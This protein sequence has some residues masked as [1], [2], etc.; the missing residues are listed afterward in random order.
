MLEKDR[1]RYAPLD[2]LS[3][4][5]LL[6]PFHQVQLLA[7]REVLFAVLF[8]FFEAILHCYFNDHRLARASTY[9][10]RITLGWLRSWTQ[11]GSLWELFSLTLLSAFSN[12]CPEEKKREQ[13]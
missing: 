9:S 11:E 7:Q 10:Y 6:W 4:R 3:F 1:T 13:I 5:A 8:A 2:V 12:V